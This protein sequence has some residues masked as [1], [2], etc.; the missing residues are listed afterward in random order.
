MNDEWMHRMSI[1]TMTPRVKAGPDIPYPSSSLNHL[2]R[3]VMKNVIFSRSGN[4]TARAS[5]HSILL[6]VS[7][8]LGSRTHISFQLQFLRSCVYVL[9]FW[10][11]Y[12]IRVVTMSRARPVQIYPPALVIF[13]VFLRARNW[14]PLFFCSPKFATFYSTQNSPLNRIWGI[15]PPPVSGFYVC[16]K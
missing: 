16:V 11:P 1:T 7:L 13:W 6:K 3:K 14:I 10:L 5:S 15:V 2:F 4:K 8:T 9:P 12:F